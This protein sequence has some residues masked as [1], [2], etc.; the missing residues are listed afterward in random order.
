[1]E[2]GYEVQV[3]IETSLQQNVVTLPRTA[4]RVN[5][6][7]QNEVLAIIDG[8]IKHS[9]VEIG[10]RNPE[11][12]EVVSGLKAGQRVVRDASMDVKENTRVKI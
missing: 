12:A 4:I 5:E 11:K 7:G 8:K 9:K 6:Q 3:R 10:I 1:L 2:P